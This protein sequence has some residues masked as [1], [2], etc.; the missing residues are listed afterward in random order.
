MQSLE[1]PLVLFTVFSQAAIGLTLMRAIRVSAGGPSGD[2]QR[3][4]RVIAGLMVV[5]MIG[6]LFHL[7][8]P[9]GAPRAVTHLGSAWLSREVLFAGLFTGVAV[10]AALALIKENTTAL[11]WIAAILGLGVI[12]SAGMTYAP[13]ALPAINNA[14]PTMF[15]LTSAVILGA[16]FGSWFAGKERQ[17][18]M[19]RIFTTALVVGLVLNLI[20]PCVWISGGTVMHMTGKAWFASGFYWTHLAVLIACLAVLWKN[21]TI[22]TWL[23]VLALL[24]E[25]AGRAGFFADTIHTATNIGG[26]Y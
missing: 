6:S 18:L 17:P 19:T 25:L 7:G 22:P 3:E 11:V 4:W 12:T 5:G 10:I 23:P 1:L 16:G 26:L 13:P 15:F 20:A 8:H 24:G 2:A 21:K 14:L 9:L